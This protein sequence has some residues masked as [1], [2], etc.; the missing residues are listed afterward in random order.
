MVLRVMFVTA[1]W[2]VLSFTACM[3]DDSS[4]EKAAL[5]AAE[6]WL[7]FVDDGQYDRSWAEA[8]E[9]FRNALTRDQWTQA[10]Q[11]AR[12]PLGKVI[13]RKVRNAAYMTSLPGAP[14][15]EYFVILFDSSF[16]NK[17]SALETVTPMLE[18]D[19]MWKVSGYYIK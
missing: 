2:L 15:G 13:S 19:G 12:K 10:L 4:K 6:Q 18:K 9:L 16:G 3:A 7:A 5:S 11:G 14:D 1:F 8:S 17:A